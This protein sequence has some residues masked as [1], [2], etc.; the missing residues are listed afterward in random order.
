MRL[1]SK[2]SVPGTTNPQP[3]RLALPQFGKIS[4]L[5]RYMSTRRGFSLAV[6]FANFQRAIGIC[7]RPL[8]CPS[9]NR[10]SPNKRVRT[11]SG[12]YQ[13]KRVIDRKRR[14]ARLIGLNVRRVLTLIHVVPAEAE[15]LKTS[16]P[17]ELL[18]DRWAVAGTIIIDD[19]PGDGRTAVATA[20]PTACSF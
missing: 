16:L 3:G 13:S 15:Q 14:Q 6:R 5:C 4:N 8:P 20:G 9:S 2:L 1:P 10:P 11:F 7:V 17:L 12:I 19:F 18:A